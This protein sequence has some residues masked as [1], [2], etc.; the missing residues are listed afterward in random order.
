MKQNPYMPIAATIDHI[1]DETLTIKTFGLR[2]VEP[3][4]FQAGQFVE[5]M[6]PGIGEAP[7]TPSSS[8]AVS[9]QMEITIMGKSNKDALAVSA[10]ARGRPGQRTASCHPPPPSASPHTEAVFHQSA[11]PSGPSWLRPCSLLCPQRCDTKKLPPPLWDARAPRQHRGLRGQP[12]GEP[13]VASFV[14]FPWL[15]RSN[16]LWTP[17]TSSF[18]VTS[19]RDLRVARDCATCGVASRSCGV[20][21]CFPR[22]SQLL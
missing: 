12:R 1:V 5:L 15:C 17:Q 3:I 8:P 11:A 2:P 18:A 19:P 7:F 13:V 20:V 9:E 10:Q 22:Q 14:S 4:A 16:F 6:V 21:L